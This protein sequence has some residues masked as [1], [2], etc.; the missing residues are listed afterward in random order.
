MT[1]TKMWDSNL[2]VELPKGTYHSPSYIKPVESVKFEAHR[3]FRS[4]YFFGQQAFDLIMKRNSVSGID[5]CPVFSDTLFVDFD[6]GDT[7]IVMFENILT[8]SGI[9]YELFFSGR[10]GF[11]FHIPLIPMWGASVP[12]S[13]KM[14]IESTGVKTADL[15]I[16][17]HTGLI[18]LPGTI[19][20]VTGV[21]KHQ[22]KKFVGNPLNIPLLEK[23][24]LEFE[25]ETFGGGSVAA[26]LSSALRSF[27]DTPGPGYRHGRLVSIG[28][29]LIEGGLSVDAT[30]EMLVLINGEWDHPK[31][32]EEINDCMRRIIQWVK[33]DVVKS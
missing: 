30:R 7:S 27:V 28:K 12:Y 17:K 3:G 10:K 6:D 11:H 18:R 20:E 1:L 32:E 15:S 13:Q 14:W 29:K 9:G 16:Y 5:E 2:Y 4:V 22:V 19:H 26:A 25:L 31:D 24:V 33:N 21:K 23:G 8:H